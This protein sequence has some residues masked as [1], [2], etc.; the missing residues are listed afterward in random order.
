MAISISMIVKVL[1]EPATAS[2]MRLPVDWDVQVTAACC[3][4]VREEDGT[5]SG[6]AGGVRDGEKDMFMG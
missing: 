1:P 6:R 5:G 4:E 3:S 2:R